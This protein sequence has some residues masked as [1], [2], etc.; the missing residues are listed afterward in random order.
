M[1][2]SSTP[3]QG[4]RRWQT[5]TQQI[6]V[7]Q[8]GREQLE[9]GSTKTD[10]QYGEDKV[11]N[12]VA[13]I[14]NMIT[15]GVDTLVIAAIDGTSL[16][17]VL[18]KAHEAKINVIAYDRLIMNSEYVDYYATFDNFGVGVL[19]ASYIEQKLGLAEGKGP[20]NI[21]ILADHLMITM[22]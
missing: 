19:Q 17:D 11:E 8:G 13:Q 20:F 2:S 15:K 9:K 14:E 10:L 4:Q 1:I 12:Q 7:G 16:T 3:Q 18:E 6:G 22:H 21:E 5:V